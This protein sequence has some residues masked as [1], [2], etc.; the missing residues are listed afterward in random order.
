[1]RTIWS[2]LVGFLRRRTLDRELDDEVGFHLEML[3]DEHRRRGMSAE[4]ARRLA[5][6]EFGGIVQ[7]KESYRD[8]RSLP[9]LETLIQ[10]ARYGIRTLFRAPAFTLAALV[11][12][13]LGIGANTAIFSVVNAVLL[14]PLPYP[15]AGR[16]VHL[17]WRGQN[18]ETVRHTGRRYLFFRD[19]LKSVD[20]LA[21][22]R[23]P[24]G[25]NLAT[26]DTAEYVT[27]MPVSKE[28]FQV[29][30]VQP[31][32][33]SAFSADHDRPEGPDAALLSHALWMRLFGGSPSV[34]GTS[35]TLGGRAYTVLGVLPR[36]FV[37]MPPADLYVPLRPGTTGA[38][39]GT[40]YFVAGRLRRELT[41]EQASAE[42]T[43]IYQSF[44]STY[45]Q[46]VQPSDLG[47]GLQAY[48]ASSARNARQPLLLMLGA[49][50]LL[51]L[52]ACANTANL[53][54]ARASGRGREI[55]VRAALGA[56]RGRIV[57]QLLTE[58]VLLFVAGGAFGVALAYAAVPA[59]LA[60][61]PSTYTNYQD[62]RVDGVVLAVML[63]VSIL[64]GLVFGL[65]PALSLS[66]QDLNEAFKDATRT[67]TS[68]RAGW[69][70]RLLVLAETSICM[71]LLVGAGLL[72]QTFIRM[73]AIDPGFDSTN[74]LTAR[75]SMQGD[76]YTTTADFN[77]FFDEALGR[78]RRLPGVR[79][80]AVVNGIPIEGALNLNVDVLDPAPGAEK[81]A[82]ALTDWRYASVNYFE[83]MGI[84][85]VAGRGFTPGDSAGAAAVAV[86]SEQFARRYLKNTNPIGHH[87]RV[88]TSDGSLEIV[89]VA[90]D[91][92]EG[93]L[94]DEGGT[95]VMY[96]PIT[97]A[98]IAGIKT[99]HTYFPMSWVVR[100]G[101]TSPELVARIREE[102]RAVDGKQPFS[103]FATMEAVKARSMRDE[104]FQM[105][106]LTVLAGLGLALAM[107][108]IYGLVS[109]GVAQHTREFGIRMA[110]GASRGR[111][112]RAVVGQGVV[113]GA[114]GVA[115]GTAM[116]IGLTRLLEDFVYGVSTID[117][118]TFLVVGAALI[119][120]AVVASLL[121]ALRAVRLNPVSA[122]RE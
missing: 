68:R 17:V 74:L 21:A 84:P 59:L 5:L 10:D 99:S 109:Y 50:G 55:G 78:I 62:V 7:M 90:K 93:S 113:L 94:R 48:Q 73:R 96:V 52:I 83:T 65:A 16:L 38:G 41:L 107:A 70:L 69:L 115:A 103:S 102:V 121:P 30:G 51:L 97:Q 14:R 92:K 47:A 67:S 58:S 61:T 95:A 24:T 33:G 6:R 76:R 20:A 75:M 122:L 8:E 81:V 85:I 64:T 53:L 89:G 56:A 35:L 43:S 57:R 13:A 86:V 116:A 3:I 114:V 91:L 32:Y 49:V 18:Y 110:L 29:F 4:D 9:W 104:T 37:S 12:L 28:Y 100:A 1:V 71:L 77:R 87:I 112:L 27:A 26:G 15:D 11:T 118:P 39:G 119:V 34:V 36:S 111:I 44:K 40:N 31:M 45:P 46:A 88:F 98:N 80:A 54:L 79:S 63:G 23:G 2:K 101:R 105:M 42:A 60:L 106:L 117:A 82:R 120:V 72:V 108:G 22:W 66:R 19:T 25:F